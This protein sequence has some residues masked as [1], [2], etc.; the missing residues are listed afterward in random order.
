MR[1]G[2][3]RALLYYY[4]APFLKTFF[5][6]LNMEVIISDET[7]K[8]IL[9]QGIKESVSEIC[10]PLKIFVGHSINLLQKG[11]DYIFIPRMVTVY[12]NEYFCP[13][14][15]GLPDMMK[16]GIKGME[17]KILTCQIH[18][19]NDDISNYKSYLPLAEALKVTEEQIKNAAKKAGDKWKVFRMYNK[20]GNPIPAALEM[21]SNY[22]NKKIANDIYGSITI[23]L[24][25]Y[26][27]N[28]YDNFVNMDVINKLRELNVN[29]I[30]FDMLDEDELMDHVK[31]MDKRLFWTF[32]N[33]LLGAGYKFFSNHEV[34]GVV[35]ITAFG[36]GPDSF[37]SR[38]LE[39]K[40]EEGGIPFML[41]RI[42]EH[43]GENHLLTRI[44]AFIDMLKRK[45]VVN[46][47]D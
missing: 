18:S 13:K 34:D 24:L 15:M 5:E 41:I 22:T 19:K 4:Y 20:M 2:I 37:L 16:H 43:T 46:Q 38:L 35:H 17:N 29:V 1:I 25:G 44:E 10:V 47:G 33:K 31:A 36:C 12:Q 26:V 39:F 32:S 30:T 14:F 21:G 23:G 40:A 9:N 42:D 45:K 8:D 27:Y 6:E 11:V 3:P 7:N 28:V